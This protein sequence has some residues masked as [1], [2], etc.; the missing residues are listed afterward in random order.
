MADLKA[1]LEI[2]ADA[3]GVEAGVSKAKRS[4]A[5]LG[6]TAST[7]GKQASDGLSGIGK[8][9]DQS[10][11]KVD[12]ATRSMIGSIQRTTAVMEAGSRSSSRYFETLAS[13]RG[14]DV[15]ALKPYLDQLDAVAA[16][17]KIAQQSIGAAT[18][19]LNAVGISAKQTAAALRGVPAQFTDI[20]TS[21]Q[22]GQAPLTVLLQQGGQLKDMF[23]GIGPAAKALGGYVLG[24][25]NPF[26]IAAAAA[27]ALAYAYY[28]GSKEA[29]AYSKAIILTGNAAGTSVNQLE[30]MAQR[31]AG[32]AG[33]QGA[34][35]EALAE[36]AASG[37]ISG[38]SLERFTGIALK[39]ERETGQAIKKTVEQFAD[40]GKEPVKASIKLNETTN[41]LTISIYQQIKALEDQGRA[42]EAGTLA[43]KAFADAIDSRMGQITG[44]LGTIERAWRG[45][46]D[47][48]T[49]AGDAILS[50]GRIST[51]QDQLN[52]VQTR[53]Q[54]LEKESASGGFANNGGGAAFGGSN[55]GVDAK[56]TQEI[57]AL[58][59]QEAAI[60]GVIFSQNMSAEAAKKAADQVKARIAF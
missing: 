46:K 25:I 43:Q 34:A 39:M 30:A 33:S 54:Q 53:I 16:K 55:S 21:I 7:A 48:V 19:T 35:A 17:Q 52:K 56:R 14:V 3:S 18:P 20:A 40:L 59:A 11:Q 6:A 38:K 22:G 57:A 58:R 28:A 2:S 47:A 12:S 49:G 4:L 23:G 37:E 31:L 42:T 50:I 13:Q 24:L 32:V 60:N 10:A 15:G 5:D 41:F 51:P 29:T 26:T 36:F 45:I 27:A 44:N 8:G 9:G 1:Q